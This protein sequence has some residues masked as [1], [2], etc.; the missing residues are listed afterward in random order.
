MYQDYNEYEKFYQTNLGKNIKY[1]I[2]SQLKKY[3]YLYDGDRVGC[4]GFSHNYL[5]NVKSERIE[6]FNCFSEKIGTKKNFENNRSVNI[7]LE[8]D[9]LPIEDLFLNHILSI[10]YLENS[11]NLKKTL[12]EFW[13]VLSPEG[14]AYL[15]LPNKKSSWSHS[16]KSPFA[17]GFGFSKKQI[18]RFLEDNF[19]EIQFIERLVYFPPWDYKLILNNKFFFEK[20]GSYFW[21][22]LNGVYLCVI[23][24]RIYATP[25]KRSLSFSEKI[26]VIKK[27]D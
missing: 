7:L 21:R 25:T 3:I 11:N 17:S 19:F 24:K 5:D 12:R 18:S 14:K 26:R 8:E 16:S 15:I 2:S 27:V 4:F 20:M 6:I 22:L 9:K 23:K 1:L 13:R 10:H